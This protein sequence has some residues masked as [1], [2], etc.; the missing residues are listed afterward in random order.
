MRDKHLGHSNGI[1]DW[2]SHGTAGGGRLGIDRALLTQTMLHYIKSFYS[3]PEGG[4]RN[5]RHMAP[6]AV[7][8]E[9]NGWRR[10]RVTSIGDSRKWKAEIAH[11]VDGA[12]RRV[13]SCLLWLCYWIA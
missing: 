6:S 9:V 10:E 3:Q 12:Q 11:A 8:K 5:D 2:I 4:T 7:D 13:R 1:L